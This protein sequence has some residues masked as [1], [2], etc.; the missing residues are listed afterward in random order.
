MEE[1]QAV[2]HGSTVCRPLE[3]AGS[4]GVGVVCWACG[5]SKLELACSAGWG[6]RCG[7]WRL[8]CRSKKRKVS[9]LTGGALS[10]AAG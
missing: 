4:R 2:L 10:C 5:N 3:A 9:Y 7:V 1:Q 6:A 8:P